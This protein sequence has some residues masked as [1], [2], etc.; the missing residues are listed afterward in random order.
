MPT[1]L[2][3]PLTSYGRSAV[4]ATG[5]MVCSSQ[6]LATMAGIRILLAGGNAI[7][8]AVAVAA[9]QNVV[10]PM[11]TG[12]GGDA[13][14]LYWSAKDQKL[15]GLNGSGKSPAGL[16]PEIFRDKKLGTIPTD[17]MLAVTVPG[18]VDMFA[19]IVAED[20]TMSLADVLQPAIQYAE[21]GF[22]VSEIIAA[23]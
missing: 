20:G 4:L 1:R 21:N 18:A 10:E 22:P 3:S 23:S 14:A 2:N 9:A 12:I 6:P 15:K 5:G 11:S 16:N 8:A 7:D 19:A 13:F 17:G